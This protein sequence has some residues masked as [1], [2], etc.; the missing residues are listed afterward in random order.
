MTQEE[1]AKAANIQRAYYTMI[2]NGTR[3]P[4]VVVA[5]RI[6]AVLG[7]DWTY[8]FK[9]KSNETTHYKKTA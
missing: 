5:K 1:V 7:V 3:N 4:S 9:H 2:E 6:G 8:F